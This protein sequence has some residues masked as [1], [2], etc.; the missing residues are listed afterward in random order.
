[1]SSLSQHEQSITTTVRHNQRGKMA[2]SSVTDML[3]LP[4][5]AEAYAASLLTAHWHPK[6]ASRYVSIVLQQAISRSK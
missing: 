1:M 4:T 5:S 6:L 3:I 2:D